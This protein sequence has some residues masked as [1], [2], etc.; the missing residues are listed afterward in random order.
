[1]KLF[2]RRSAGGGRE[3]AP[4][5]FPRRDLGAFFLSRMISSII[6]QIPGRRA[7][8]SMEYIGLIGDGSC[9]TYGLRTSGIRLPIRGLV[10]PNG[11]NGMQGLMRHDHDGSWIAGFHNPLAEEEMQAR[12]WNSRVGKDHLDSLI[13]QEIVKPVPGSHGLH[14]PLSRDEGDWP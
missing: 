11:I 13:R 7:R 3:T 5:R 6:P 8:L 4:D 9:F 1:M 14:T 10:F 2:P 12:Y